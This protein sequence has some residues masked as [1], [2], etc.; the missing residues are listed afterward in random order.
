MHKVCKN[1]KTRDTRRYRIDSD[2]KAKQAQAN[3]KSEPQFFRN[4]NKIQK[5][6]YYKRDRTQQGR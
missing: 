3:Q 4:E 2:D 6:Y 1:L 5:A